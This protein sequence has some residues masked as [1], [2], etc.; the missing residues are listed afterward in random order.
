MGWR[1]IAARLRHAVTGGRYGR[2]ETLPTA[3]EFAAE[4][5]VSEATVQRACD[6]LRSEGLIRPRSGRGTIVNPLPIL[7]RDAIARQRRDVREAGQARGAFDAELRAAGFVPR[8]DVQVTEVT[9]PSEVA[10]LLGTGYGDAV[11]ARSR[12]M[13]ADDEPVQMATSYLP[14]DITAG[15]PVAGSDPGPGGIYSRLADLGHEIAWFSETVRVRTPSDDEALFLH[16]D[17][18]HRVLAIRRTATSSAGRAVEV[19]EIVL[20]AHQW[21]LAYEWPA[22]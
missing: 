3:G 17:P 10:E 18:D 20:P 16:L 6:Q 11:L 21:E 5:G 9:A 2:G 19:N 13:Y 1:E 22:Q 15:T 8:T 12:R 7:R 14:L 4:F